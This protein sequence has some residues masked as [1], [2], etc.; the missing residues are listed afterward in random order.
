MSL[1]KYLITLGIATFFCWLAWVL[2]LSF[3]NPF[4]AGTIGLFCFYTSLF[5]YLPGTFAIIGFLLRRVMNRKEAPFRYLGV[6]L[7]QGLLLSVLIVGS[8]FLQGNR[9]FVWWSL[10]LLTL[11]LIILEIFFLTRTPH[12]LKTESRKS[13]SKPTHASIT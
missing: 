3:I 2:V 7:R 1:R 12:I 9:L 5:F 13:H 8:L 11:G 10:L 4:Q 6:S